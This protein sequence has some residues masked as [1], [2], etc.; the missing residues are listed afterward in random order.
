MTDFAAIAR[1]AHEAGMKAAEE[2]NVQMIGVQGYAGSFPICGFAWIRFP[3]NTAWGRWAKKNAG[4]SK[5]YPTGLSI[6]VSQFNQSVDRKYAY[7]RAY[8]NVLNSHGIKA[9]ADSRLD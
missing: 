3:G 5:A 6:W 2:A 9:H 7:A 4:A 8:A 1:E